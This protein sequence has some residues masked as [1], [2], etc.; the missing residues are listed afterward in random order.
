MK[1][2]AFLALALPLVLTAC[3]QSTDNKS[4]SA[5]APA[6]AAPAATSAPPPPAASAPPPATPTP[7]APGDAIGYATV[8]E[9]R[10]A[11]NQRK[12][13]TSREDDGWLIVADQPAGAFWSFTPPDDAANPAVI[14]RTIH[15]KEGK[16]SVAMATLCEAPKPACDNL[17]R[18]F[19]DLNERMRADLQH[20]ADAHK[21]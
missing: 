4:A 17:V 2:I 16:V 9:A 15:E 11:I 7:L 5:P 6:V 10:A 1:P 8:A 14:K 3:G 12:D 20:Q 19:E 18:Q 13:V 21:Q